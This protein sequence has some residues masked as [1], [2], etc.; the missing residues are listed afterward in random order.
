M[1]AITRETIT[2]EK[3]QELA[4]MGVHL[5]IEYRCER[6]EVPWKYAELW[7]QHHFEFLLD[8]KGRVWVV[9]DFPEEP[10]CWVPEEETWL[11]QTEIEGRDED[12]ESSLEEG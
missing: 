9:T 5:L 11:E 8:N 3:A 6:D 12:I 1:E 4:P 10:G 7:I 2:F